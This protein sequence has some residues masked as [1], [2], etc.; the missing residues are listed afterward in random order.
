MIFAVVLLRLAVMPKYL[1]SYLNMAYHKLE[2]LRQ[3][4]GKV[5]NIEFQ[6]MIAR[7]FYYLCVVWPTVLFIMYLHQIAFKILLFSSG[8]FAVRGSIDNDIVLI[9]NV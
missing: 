6:K 3:E 4:A 8:Y 7:V 9:T 5:T 2:E 1:Q